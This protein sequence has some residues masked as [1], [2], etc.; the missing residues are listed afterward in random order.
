MRQLV[1]ALVCAYQSAN[2]LAHSK[3]YPKRFIR[4]RSL[5]FSSTDR[6]NHNILSTVTTAFACYRT[7]SSKQCLFARHCLKVSQ[8]YVSFSACPDDRVPPLKHPA[9]LKNRALGTKFDMQAEGL[10][11]EK[12]R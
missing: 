6:T 10:E 8:R 11:E 7:E 2:K 9:K 1:G 4:S 3:V 12:K 5:T